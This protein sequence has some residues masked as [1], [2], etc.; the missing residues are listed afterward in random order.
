MVSEELLA[1]L[2]FVVALSPLA[3]PEACGAEAKLGTVL[4]SR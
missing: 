1:E 4:S 2:L 3:L